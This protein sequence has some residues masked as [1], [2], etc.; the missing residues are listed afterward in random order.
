MNAPAIVIRLSLE[1]RPYV[2]I[3]AIHES[4]ERRLTEWLESKPQYAELVARALELEREE[5]AA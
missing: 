4:D 3:D 1:A 2:Y 5:R